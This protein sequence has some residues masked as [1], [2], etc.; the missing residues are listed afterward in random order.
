MGDDSRKTGFI[1]LMFLLWGGLLMKHVTEMN[2]SLNLMR[3]L[4]R[5]SDDQAAD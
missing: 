5:D 4:D 3:M 1:R 2:W